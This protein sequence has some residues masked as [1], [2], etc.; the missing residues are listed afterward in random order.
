[1]STISNNLA[2]LQATFINATTGL[3][4]GGLA[5]IVPTTA[6]NNWEDMTTATNDFGSGWNWEGVVGAANG[7][8]KF[9]DLYRILADTTGANPTGTLRTGAW[10]G[11]LSLGSDGV[12]TFASTVAAIPEPSRA[13]LALGGLTAL[14]MRRR[15][16]A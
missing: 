16:R 8:G 3:Q 11:T 9:L 14:F 12:V 7:A 4:N 10:Q 1:M 6:N 13:I 5:A 15:R 2:G